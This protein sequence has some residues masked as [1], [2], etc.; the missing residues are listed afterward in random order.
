M[1]MTLKDL[2][3]MGQ[4]A[5]DISEFCIDDKECDFLE[6]TIEYDLD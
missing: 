1:H 6:S 4:K 5:I 2:P 3:D